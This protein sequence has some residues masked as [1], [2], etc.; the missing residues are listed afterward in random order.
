MSMFFRD[1]IGQSEAKQHLLTLKRE[2]RIPHAMLFCG[3][4]GT[5]KLPLP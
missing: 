4:D 1:V 2:G 5:G 3:M